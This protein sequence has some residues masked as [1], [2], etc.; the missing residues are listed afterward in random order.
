M[1]YFILLVAAVL[2]P[3]SA[4]LASDLTYRPFESKDRRFVTALFG[5]FISRAHGRYAGKAT[6]TH[7][8]TF[9]RATC[10]VAEHK[11]GLV[12]F[13][14]FATMRQHAPVYIYSAN[15]DQARGVTSIISEYN[16]VLRK[17]ANRRTKDLENDI[18]AQAFTQGGG[19]N[20]SKP[21]VTYFE[22]DK[23]KRL[24]PVHELDVVLSAVAA[25]DGVAEGKPTFEPSEYNG[26]ELELVTRA[27]KKAKSAGFGAMHASC[28][29]GGYELPLF[30]KAGFRKA[31]SLE[32]WYADGNGMTHV[33]LKLNDMNRQ[34][35]AALRKRQIMEAAGFPMPAIRP[36]TVPH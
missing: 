9:K 29:M 8:P 22:T 19:K 6:E 26:V 4:V 28:W 31:A 14:H 15:S 5:K 17:I 35:N 33:F 12:G 23:L 16:T 25:Y 30:E 32:P 24:L 34:E 20:R 11:K 3:S 13:V 18:R 2:L 27:I 7:L 21:N 36:G 1:K 10:L